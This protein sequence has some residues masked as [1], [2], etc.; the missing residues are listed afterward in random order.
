MN[1]YI[2]TKVCLHIQILISLPCK[3]H[4]NSKEGCIM[5]ERLETNAQHAQL[6]FSFVPKFDWSKQVVFSNF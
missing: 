4:T 6:T 5:R 1:V 2:Q 3:I